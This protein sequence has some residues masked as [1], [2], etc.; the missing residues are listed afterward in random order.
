MIA[1]RA[2]AQ[3]GAGPAPR[4][5][6]FAEDSK[7]IMEQEFHRIKRLLPDVFAEVN[8]LKARARAASADRRLAS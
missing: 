3:T 4:R 2:G 7:G 5:R 8:E 1:V 6:G